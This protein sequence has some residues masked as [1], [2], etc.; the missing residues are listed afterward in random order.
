VVWVI[1]YLN[2]GMGFMLLIIGTDQVERGILTRAALYPQLSLNSKALLFT[3][4]A[5]LVACVWPWMLFHRG[6]P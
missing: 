4:G 3:I 5:F 6:K 2:I 1:L